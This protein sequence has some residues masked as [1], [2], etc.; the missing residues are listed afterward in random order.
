[1]K[2]N[3]GNRSHCP[4]SKDHTT[5]AELLRDAYKRNRHSGE[6]D[7]KP[8]PDEMQHLYVDPGK[9]AVRH[10]VIEAMLRRRGF[11]VVA[12]AVCAVRLPFSVDQ[13][14]RSKITSSITG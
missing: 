6:Y 8:D 2:R 14:S 11:A 9:Q 1:M 13:S 3:G 4:L 5:F 12:S 7:P 10:E